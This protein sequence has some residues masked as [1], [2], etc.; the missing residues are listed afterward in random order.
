MSSRCLSL[1]H[2]H[3]SPEGRRARFPPL[4]GEGGKSSILESA[5][6]ARPFNTCP[7]IASNREPWQGQ[8]QLSSVAFHVTMQPRWVHTAER[9]CSVP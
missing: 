2:P 8:S 9:W 4:V 6:F 3:P 1:L 5:E 7:S